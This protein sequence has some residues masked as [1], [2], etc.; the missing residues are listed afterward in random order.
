MRSYVRHEKKQ[1]GD[2]TPNQ[3][4]VQSIVCVRMLR[5]QLCCVQ[6]LLLNDGTSFCP[7]A[8]RIAT[9]PFFINY[10]MI[11]RDNAYI[12][13]KHINRRVVYFITLHQFTNKNKR[14]GTY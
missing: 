1:Q 4:I 12:T 10:N 6:Q 11:I 8:L 5:R 7:G 2:V 13:H 9:G 14:N 3:S